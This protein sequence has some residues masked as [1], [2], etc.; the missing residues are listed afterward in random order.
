MSDLTHIGPDGRA[1]MVDVGAKA[2]TERVAIAHGRVR[3]Q[4]ET[5]ELAASRGVNT[6]LVSLGG[7]AVLFRGTMQ[8][9]NEFLEA[10]EYWP[11]TNFHGTDSL[12]AFVRRY[13]QRGLADRRLHSP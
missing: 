10:V 5:L 3:M 9:I 7:N 13:V 6:A 8:K 12:V 1:R 2:V 11:D 4:A